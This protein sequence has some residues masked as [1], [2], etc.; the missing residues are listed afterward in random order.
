MNIK[1][2][3]PNLG[4]TIFSVMSA[5]SNQ[6]N[7]I[8][9]SQGFP[10][11]DCDERL[12]KLVASYINRGY[13]QYCPMT[14]AAPLVER[15][16]IKIQQLYGIEYDP[17]NEINITSGATQAIFSTIHAFI[18]S[19]DEV[20]IVEPAYD[21]YQPSI[22]LAGGVVVPYQIKAPD[23]KIDWKEFEK[24]LSPKTRMIILNTPHNPSGS[25]LEDNDFLSLQKIVKD[26]D[27]VILSD[28]VYEHMV[29]DDKK[30]CS[31][32]EYPALRKR[33]LATF[34]FGKTLHATGWKL[35]YIVGDATLMHEFRKIHQFDVFTSNTP[36][37]YAIAD[38]LE[39]ESTYL[40]LPNF[41][42]TKRDFFLNSIE[43]SPFKYLPS[44][45]TY[46]QVA[47]Y[48]DISDEPD[49]EFARRMTIEYGVA[50]IPISVFYHNN[51]D[52]RVVRFCFAKTEDVLQK[53]AEMICNIK[54]KV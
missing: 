35:G 25:I 13:N 49:T 18:H 44:S 14:G 28:E 48:S 52:N 41:F 24:L 22:L 16:A 17:K 20:I 19:G 50:V 54:R 47:D 3:L 46:F 9:L 38:Y 33:S 7:A 45:G 27:I 1:S 34:S 23:W 53:A 32:L 40:D 4:T 11:F 51:L 12:K 5:L 43:Q 31:I 8:N 2:K 42:Q 30:H 29:F 39:D 15:L 6:Y 21:C 36:F 37:Q 10:N 26:T